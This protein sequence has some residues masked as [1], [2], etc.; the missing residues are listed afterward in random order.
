MKNINMNVRSH[1]CF[2]CYIKRNNRDVLI[3]YLKKVSYDKLSYNFDPTKELL[4]D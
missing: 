1:C 2:M 4:S 3:Y